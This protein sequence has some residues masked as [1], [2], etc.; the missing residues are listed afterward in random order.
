MDTTQGAV[1]AGIATYRGKLD[2]AER[3]TRDVNNI[4]GMIAAAQGMDALARF[5]ETTAATT[6]TKAS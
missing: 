3:S 1:T 6:P 2:Q 4:R 5:D